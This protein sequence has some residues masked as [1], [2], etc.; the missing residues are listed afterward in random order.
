MNSLS[1]LIYLADIVG[2]LQGVSWAFFAFL[3]LIAGIIFLS[4]TVNVADD[5][6]SKWSRNYNENTVYPS[7]S[8]EGWKKVKYFVFPTLFAAFLAV[9]TPASSTI[10]AIAASEMGEEILKSETASKAQKALNAWLDKQIED[11]PEATK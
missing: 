11:K 6:P 8:A 7:P 2:K 4:T 5:I 1:W 10:Y 3:I 9:I